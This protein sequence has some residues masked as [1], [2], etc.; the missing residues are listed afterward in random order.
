VEDVT[1]PNS[2]YRVIE[3]TLL[4]LV[5]RILPPNSR[6]IGIEN[7]ITTGVKDI[8]LPNSRYRVTEEHNYI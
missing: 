6:E 2:R 1:L 5:W 3:G 8:K 7:T 4:H